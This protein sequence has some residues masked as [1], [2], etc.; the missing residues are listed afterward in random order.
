M[1]R[2]LHPLLATL[3]ALA[4]LVPA[5]AAQQTATNAPAARATKPAAPTASFERDWF[6]MSKSPERYARLQQMVGSPAPELKIQRWTGEPMSLRG[7]R[8]KIVVLDFWGTWCAPCLKAMPHT[9]DV[10]EAYRSRGVE[11]IGV[12]DGLNGAGTFDEV[13]ESHR[14]AFP[15]AL[16]RGRATFTAYRGEWFPFL[17]L[18]DRKGVIRARGLNPRT[19]EKAIDALLDEQPSP[20]ADPT[21]ALLEGDLLERRR[22]A[23][24]TD[25]QAPPLDN[26]RWIVPPGESDDGPAAATLV[27]FWGMWSE[28]G[29]ASIDRAEAL[30]RSYADRGL[31]I[32]SVCHPKQAEEAERFVAAKAPGYAV[33][34]DTDGEVFEAFRVNHAPDYY[35]LDADGRVVLADV[36]EDGLEGAIEH[37][38]GVSGP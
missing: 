31:R 8:G 16:D 35:L 12:C 2:R 9:N 3:V 29:K 14:I 34:V 38:L 11:I 28:L 1:I 10:Y 24:L 15:T 23:G 33:G 7:L 5:T 17:V 6:L 18:I 21:D 22:L 37:V 25:A 36:A 32:I 26:L 27:C 19:L 4:L 13:F 30:R 20:D